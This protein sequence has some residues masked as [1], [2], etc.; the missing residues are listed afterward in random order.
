MDS[1]EEKL[2][3]QAKARKLNLR[4]METYQ[5]K[6]KHGQAYFR[7]NFVCRELERKIWEEI[8]NEIPKFTP[9]TYKVGSIEVKTPRL[10]FAYSNT[11]LKYQYSG[12][13]RSTQSWL[14]SLEILRDQIQPF[15]SHPLNFALVN[16]YR[17]LNDSI[18]WHSDEEAIVSGSDIASFSLRATRNFQVK[19]RY[20]N[21]GM[22][23]IS[24]SL[25][26]ASW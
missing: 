14:P 26:T 12:N 5:S 9:D 18:G 1:G 3:N 11:G 7:S 13:V 21:T 17:N 2:S 25:T 22:L 16:V 19:G 10:V 6:D 24:I 8:L 23:V 4:L 15:C 20:Q